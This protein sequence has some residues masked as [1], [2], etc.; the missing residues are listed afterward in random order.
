MDNK[1]Q[2]LSEQETIVETLIE[3]TQAPL[4]EH[5][6]NYI[7]LK[8]KK[9]FKPYEQISGLVMS[10][11]PVLGFVIFGLI[12]MILAFYMAFCEI[13]GFDILTAEFVGFQNFITV[14]NDSAFWDS[15]VNTLI[16]AISLPVCLVISLTVSFLL[17]KKIH[18]KKIFKTIF[19]VPYVCS[20]VAVVLMW[21]WIFNETYGV[22]NGIIGEE[23]HWLTDDSLFR[24][25]VIIIGI[26]GGCGYQIILY[27]A[28]LTNI[29]PS[30]Y[31]AAKI[32]GANAFQCFRHVT[33]PGVSPTTFYLLITG[34]I[35]ALQTFAST[36]VLASDGGPNN[37]GVTIGF[38]LYRYAFNY[39]K[40]GQASATAWILAI[41]I[42]I[43]TIINFKVSKKWVN[44]DQ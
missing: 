42:V 4:N 20:I 18:G 27:S 39:F 40:M 41:L 31:E 30:L 33:L 13:K 21:K 44:Y 12:P 35:G 16:F 25:V 22:V 10:L 32:D 1:D 17:T 6:N 19:F 34:L 9:S 15:V 5:V 38:Y 26:W 8:R 28:A 11:G 36:Q 29:N 23:I 43:I 3:E 24:F 37:V 7:E 2:L 14:L